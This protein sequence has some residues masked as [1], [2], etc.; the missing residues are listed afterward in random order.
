MEKIELK[1]VP[2]FGFFN[3]P[4][5]CN[6]CNGDDIVEDKKRGD[7]VCRNCGLVLHS[8]LVD[9][10]SEWRGFSENQKNNDP[11]RIGTPA[12]PLFN[13][14]LGTILSKGLKGSNFLNE[15]LIRTQNQSAM[16]KTDRFWR[17]SWA[18]H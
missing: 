11:C 12:N 4:E 15:K 14:R 3:C 7:M 9:F 5:K 1:E 17:F 13:S 8:H 16:Q 6:E 10:T 18:H 2:A